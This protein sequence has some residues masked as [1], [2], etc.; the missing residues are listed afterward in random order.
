MRLFIAGII[1]L[2]ILIYL[3]HFISNLIVEK[4]CT[5]IAHGNYMFY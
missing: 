3:V 4:K 2:V 1:A 5:E